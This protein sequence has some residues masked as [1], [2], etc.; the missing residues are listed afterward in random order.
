[1]SPKQAKIH[2]ASLLKSEDSD[3]NILLRGMPGVAKTAIIK[4]AAE[5]AGYKLIMV[6]GVTSDPIDAKGLPAV[7]QDNNTLEHRAEFLPFGEM[8]EMIEADSPTLVFLDDLGQAP[9]AVQAAWMQPIHDRR[10][11]GFRVPDCVRFIA[12]TNRRQDRAGAG[13]LITPLRS[14]LNFCVTIDPDLG[15]WAEY[16]LKDKTIDPIVISFARFVNQENDS[17]FIFDPS[18]DEAPCVPRTLTAMGR[19]VK[20]LGKGITTEVAQGCIGEAMGTKF[21]AFL[22]TYSELPSLES[23]LLNPDTAAVPERP[24]VLYALSGAMSMKANENN[25]DGI[26]TYSNRM[27]REFGVG[28]VKDICLRVESE[29]K[30]NVFL[31]SKALQTW[32]RE[33][34]DLIYN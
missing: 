5:E 33:N 16:S 7:T 24:D 10:L 1:M 34:H 4:A 6:H 30:G 21:M 20:T 17:V 23:I 27:P 22:K 15:D 29:R 12:A 28:L 2:I 32:M 8:R 13:D 3:T 31:K 26:I 9:K 25:I 18:K 11:N 19:L 14:R